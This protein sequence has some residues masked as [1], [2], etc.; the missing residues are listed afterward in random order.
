MLTKAD[1]VQIEL[2]RQATPERRTELMARL[3][4]DMRRVAMH[5]IAEAFPHLDE[6]QRK[7]EGDL[8][9]RGLL[10]RDG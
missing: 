7:L 3:S 1:R 10:R 2:L 9:R 6:W 8:V 5:G 4:S